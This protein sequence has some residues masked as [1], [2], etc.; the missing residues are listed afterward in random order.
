M[1][2]VVQAGAIL[3]R[4]SRKT[5]VRRKPQYPESNENQPGR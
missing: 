3:G 1:G 4:V 5:S 2:V